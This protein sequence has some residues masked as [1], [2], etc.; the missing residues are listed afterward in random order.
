MRSRTRPRT[1][2]KFVHL[3]YSL[4]VLILTYMCCILS[5]PYLVLRHDHSTTHDR[6]PRKSVDEEQELMLLV[7]GKPDDQ[8]QHE[9]QET[10]TVW[11]IFHR[12]SANEQQQQQYQDH[13]RRHHHLVHQHD[14]QQSTSTST[15]PSRSTINNPS[16]IHFLVVEEDE[17]EA[18]KENGNPVREDTGKNIGGNSTRRRKEGV[19]ERWDSSRRSHISS[20]SLL[21]SS[22]RHAAGVSLSVPSN[23]E[24]LPSCDIRAI[25]TTRAS[26][27]FDAL[28]SKVVCELKL[29]RIKNNERMVRSRFKNA[30]ITNKIAIGNESQHHVQDQ[31]KSNIQIT[32]KFIL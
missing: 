30:Q 7:I 19:E 4:V 25:P 24:S 28:G 12:N 22:A 16:A 23:H 18:I 3:K 10:G 5:I 32:S 15:M 2:I 14:Q 8:Q 27:S 17:K 6:R 1:I 11:K 9:K 21:S 20:S 31:S 13:H 29:E 26:F